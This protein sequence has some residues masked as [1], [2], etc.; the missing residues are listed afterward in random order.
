MLVCFGLFRYL[1]FGLLVPKS[2][3]NILLEHQGISKSTIFNK[4]P[5]GP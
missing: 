4:R 2:E 5:A 1:C 3:N